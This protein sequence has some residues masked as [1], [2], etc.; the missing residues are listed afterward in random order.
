MYITATRLCSKDGTTHQDNIYGTHYSSNH[1]MIVR[2]TDYINQNVV[3]LYDYEIYLVCKTVA[4]EIGHAYGV[5]D[6]YNTVYGDDRDNCI[7]GRNKNNPDVYED[8][9]ICDECR[10]TILANGNKFNYT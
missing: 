6:H 3:S 7:W 5:A 9:V 8:L 4:H 10:Q 1:T 2:D